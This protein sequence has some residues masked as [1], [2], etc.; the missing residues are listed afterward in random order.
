MNKRKIKNNKN[1]RRGPKARRAGPTKLPNTPFVLL[2][3]PDF[4]HTFQ[5]ICTTTPASK[6]P[7]TRANVLN[8]I[9]VA[10]GAGLAS[11]QILGALRVRRV[12][13]W[14][15]IVSAFTPEFV[16]IEW[17][18]GLYAPSAIHSAISE[19]LFPAKLATRPPPMSSPDLWTLSGASNLTEVLFTVTCPVGSVL[20]VEVAA[21]L[22]DDEPAAQGDQ[23]VA[24][25]G[26]VY[27]GPLDGFASNTL[28][29]SGGVRPAV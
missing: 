19:G 24:T 20:Q 7:V 10:L 28:V 16:E 1:N 6:L 11:F 29:A 26:T 12:S 13:I 21:R 3:T 5:F 18:G 15:P 14:S 8:L 22:I 2:A 17:N 23:G 25:A 9:Q 27:Y 4:G